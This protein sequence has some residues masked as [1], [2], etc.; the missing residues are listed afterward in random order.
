MR[1]CVFGA[2]AVGS[3]LAVRLIQS[4]RAEIAVVARGPHLA[5]MAS[6]GL[7]L[8]SEDGTT[9]VPVAVATDQ[10]ASLPPQDLVIVTLKGPSIPPNAAAI[11]ALLAPGGVAAFLINGIPWWWRFGQEATPGPLPLVDPDGRTWNAVRPERAIGGVIYSPNEIIAPGIVRHR[12]RNHYVLGLPQGGGSPA[13]SAMVDLFAGAGIGVE[14]TT[15][16]RRAVWLKL[17]LNAPGNPT[18]ALTCLS[19]AAR[20]TVPGLSD[21]GQ[22]IVEEVIAVAMATGTDIRVEGGELAESARRNRPGGRP[23]M[24]QDVEAGRPME[25]ESLLG[26]VQ[27]FAR[28]TGVETPVIDVLVPLLR[29]LDRAVSGR[30]PG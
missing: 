13:L 20:A 22:R 5:A 8:E 3:H 15:D 19:G 14:S 21:L 27:A 24:L 1:V 12:S 2:G 23:S 7:T 17:L 18:A 9:T 10:P 30:A 4:G 26:Q 16:I 6:R 29:G 25:V 11:A 28:E